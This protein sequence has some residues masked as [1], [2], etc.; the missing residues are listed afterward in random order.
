MHDIHAILQKHFG[1][2]SFR[3]VQQEVIESVL[4]KKDTL[5]LLPTGGGKS[6]C[7]QIPALAT[8]GIC[9]VV[10]P[11]IAL[12]KDQAR[13]LQSRQIPALL[14]HSGMPFFEVKKMLQN[15]T[16]D[17]FK[18]LFV[19]PERLQTALFQEYL[20]AIPINL[21]AVDE[22]HCISQWGYD[23]RPSYLNIADL[24]QAKPDV[25]VLALTAS[26]TQQVQ[27]DIMEKLAFRKQQV[28]R[29]SFA[30][31]NLSFSAYALAEKTTQLLRVLRNVKG[32]ALVYCRNRRLTKE[33]AEWLMANDINAGHYHAG[34]D[35]EERNKRQEAW[36]KNQLRVMVCTNAFGM[37]IDKPDVRAVIHLDMPESLEYYY[38]EAGR[39]GRDGDRSYAVLLYNQSDLT[40]LEQIV[41]EKFPPLEQVRNIYSDVCNYVGVPY[42]AGAGSYQSFV[43]ENFCERFKHAPILVLASL[44]LL[45]QAGYISLSDN[46]Q[47]RS[48]ISFTC[49]K[50]WLYQ[51]E[52]EHAS[53]EPI[54]KTLLRTY[55]GIFT[56]EVSISEKQLAGLLRTDEAQVVK[57]LAALAAQQVI[58]YKPRTDKPQLYFHHHRYPADQLQ[59]DHKFLQQQKILW[60][61]RITAMLT[62]AQDGKQC[63]SAVIR[64]YFNDRDTTPCGICDNCLNKK[65]QPSAVNL[66]H[67]AAQLMQLLKQENNPDKLRSLLRLNEDS[68]TILLDYMLAEEKIKVDDSGM[69]IANT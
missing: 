44:R 18:F 41:S 29:Q 65:Q 28:F 56:N 50:D 12:M 68:F 24:R 53:L 49:D 3:G 43:L 60:Q 15:A 6:L 52:T 36:T 20:P 23:F 11:L 32:S 62:Y 25:P 10:T 63:R 14:M 69:L 17:G 8:P 21:L 35:T 59:F 57:Q 30:R 7:Y 54:I 67:Y 37:G 48:R 58:D 16:G 51:F 42:N 2:A 9:L 19:S 13:Q 31:P 5:A 55:E 1:F 38:Q 61:K 46:I 26:A 39:A 22:A 27:A 66:Q 64:Q 40:R 33:I 4:N 45:Q 47:L 34:L